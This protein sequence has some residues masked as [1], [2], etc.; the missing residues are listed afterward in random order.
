MNFEEKELKKNPAAKLFEAILLLETTDEVERFM[1]DL[2]TPQ[3]IS[4]LAERWRVCRLL[5]QDTLSYRE[6]SQKTGASLAT[7]TRVAR[8]LKTE[9][10]QGYAAVLKKM[11]LDK[12]KKQRN[13]T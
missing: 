1:R 8:F 9:A 6:I 2:C 13:L 4:A 11:K 10:H 5:A 3:E 7:I 12:N